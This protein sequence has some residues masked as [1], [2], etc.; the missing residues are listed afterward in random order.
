MSGNVVIKIGL[1]FNLKVAADKA[2]ANDLRSLDN[3]L[4][5]F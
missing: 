3:L 4:E 2:A 5:K 1:E